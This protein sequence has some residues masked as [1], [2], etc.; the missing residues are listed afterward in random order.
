MNIPSNFN[1]QTKEFV[2]V[3]TKFCLYLSKFGTKAM[4][5]YLDS[6]PVKM[7]KTDGKHLGAYIIGKVLESCE[8]SG[9]PFSRY[10]LFNSKE[11]RQ[12]LA[13]ARMLLCVLA[14]KYVKLDNGEISSMFNKSR[15]FAKRAL[16]DFSK[17]DEAIPAHRKLLAK[18]KKLDTLVNAYVNF[19]PKS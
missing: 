15:D 6:I 11:R 14:H 16:S 9:T 3:F 8:Q 17:L 1:V 13:E 5:A 2:Q 10:E 19:T 12:E 7:G 18:H 4:D